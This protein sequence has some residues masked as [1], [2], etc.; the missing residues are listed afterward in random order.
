MQAGGV[1]TFRLSLKCLFITS[2]AAET[3]FIIRAFPHLWRGCRKELHKVLGHYLAGK[4]LEPL[5][6]RG[7]S[8]KLSAIHNLYNILAPIAVKFS[9]EKKCLW[10]EFYKSGNTNCNL[11]LQVDGDTS[12]NDTLLAFSSGASGSILVSSTDCP[13]GQ[14]LQMALDAVTLLSYPDNSSFNNVHAVSFCLSTSS[15]FNGDLHF[16]RF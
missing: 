13:E 14:E 11:P 9:S 10:L 12:T 7:Q 4:I 15:C 6:C 16:D 2:S 1:K 8:R 5:K 3:D